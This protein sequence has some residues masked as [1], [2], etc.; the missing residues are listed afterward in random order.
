MST[1]IVPRHTRAC[2]SRSGGKCS[3]KVTY[4]AWVWDSR[5]RKK[6]K[7]SFATQAAAK[8]LAR[9]RDGTNS[10]VRRRAGWDRGAGR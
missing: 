2:A 3:C 7:K 8:K 1:G 4:G 10:V 9:R 6:V 5:T